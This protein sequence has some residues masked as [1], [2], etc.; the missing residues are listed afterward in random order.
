MAKRGCKCCGTWCGVSGC[1][2]CERGALCEMCK[3]GDHAS[4]KCEGRKAS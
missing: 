1:E 2:V 4:E 3:H